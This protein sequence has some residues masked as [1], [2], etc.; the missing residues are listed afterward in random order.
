MSSPEKKRDDQLE[1]DRIAYFSS[2]AQTNSFVRVRSP[3]QYGE[4]TC[5]QSSTE[6]SIW[7]TSERLEYQAAL[8]HEQLHR[9]E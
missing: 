6:Y 2:N 9:A 3:V 8:R 4:C 5:I 7:S 1:T